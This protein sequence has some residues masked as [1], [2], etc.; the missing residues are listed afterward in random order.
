MTVAA[1]FAVAVALLSGCAT[2]D[3]INAVSLGMTKAEVIRAIGQPIS[4]SAAN[5]VEILNYALREG[6]GFARA[7]TP[8]SVQIVDGHVVSYGRQ[9][10]FGTPPQTNQAIEATNTPKQ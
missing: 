1:A 5:G 10:D 3:R 4:T 7:N 8:Y 9:G 6:F 2:A